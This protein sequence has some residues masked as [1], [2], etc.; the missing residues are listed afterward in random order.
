MPRPLKALAAISTAGVI[1]L[2]FAFFF[3]TAPDP[4]GT[5]ANDRAFNIWAAIIGFGG[6]G[7]VLAYGLV[8]LGSHYGRR[9]K[10]TKNA[11]S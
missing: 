11:N 10:R 5:D 1:G 4:Y 3:A 8:G 2:L 7:S 9:L 6:I